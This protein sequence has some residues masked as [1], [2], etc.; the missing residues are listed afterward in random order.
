MPV[1]AGINRT[2]NRDMHH[3]EGG[4]RKQAALTLH[5][6]AIVGLLADADDDLRHEAAVTPG[7][8]T[9]AALTLHADAI[10]H[11]LADDNARVRLAAM[12]TPGTL[13]ETVRAVTFAVA[14]AAPA[15]V[16]AADATN[17]T[18]LVI[19]SICRDK[20]MTITVGPCDSIYSV[21]AKILDGC[22]ADWKL[23]NCMRMLYN[24]EILNETH[25]LSDYTIVHGSAVIV[26]RKCRVRE[27][28]HESRHS[29]PGPTAYESGC[30]LVTHISKPAVGANITTT[31]DA[32]DSDTDRSADRSAA[33]ATSSDRADEVAHIS[34][35]CKRMKRDGVDVA[36]VDV[37]G[38]TLRYRVRSTCTSGDWYATSPEGGT[39]R[40]FAALQRR[41][42][43]AT[44][45]ADSAAAAARSAPG[46]SYSTCTEFPMQRVPA[47]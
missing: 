24:G 4:H 20:S 1:A 23:S 16:A 47:N 17:A 25:Q 42:A 5:A 8:L 46:R 27:C 37:L 3:G 19:C 31:A 2:L 6:G 40:S 7:K 21:K 28:R 43:V 38:W 45:T 11:V 9:Q 30:P 41:V 39:Y 35:A 12:E 18:K 36:A 13:D 15:T 44:A 22:T 14:D 29:R 32:G 26:L 34:A 33:H 10:V